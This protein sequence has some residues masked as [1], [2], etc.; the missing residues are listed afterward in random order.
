MSTEA[1]IHA[2]QDHC[3]APT[4]DG[5]L[6]RLTRRR[7][8]DVQTAQMVHEKVNS[9]LSRF[10]NDSVLHRSYVG[11]TEMLNRL[12]SSLL[13]NA[14]IT[15]CLKLYTIPTVLCIRM[16]MVRIWLIELYDMLPELKMCV[17]H[18]EY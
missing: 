1:I 17:L 10:P 6:S 14:Q 15:N 18:M 9:V 3:P 2:T 4:T 5:S 13:I 16:C 7:S 12:D 8:A 11:T